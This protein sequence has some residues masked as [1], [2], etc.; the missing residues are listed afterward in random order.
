M[1]L[2]SKDLGTPVVDPVWRP[3]GPREAA[4]RLERFRR[5]WY[6]V[7]GWAVDLF[8]GEQTRDHDDLELGIPRVAFAALRAE[9]SD[10]EFSVVGDGR[11]FAVTPH[12][13]EEHFQT[14]GWSGTAG[15]YVVDVFRDPHE[16]DVWECRRDPTIRR[17]FDELVR[18]TPDGIPYLA[19]EVV[20][21]FKAKHLRDKDEHDWALVRPRLDAPARSWLRAALARVHPGH[22]WLVALDDDD[23]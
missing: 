10:L 12:A 23:V 20:M 19:P 8:L 7:A 13:L 17:P 15:G 16:G 4:E 1:R 11:Q 6:V 21:L 22:P 3:W 14:W 9:L 18:C 2:V 5:P